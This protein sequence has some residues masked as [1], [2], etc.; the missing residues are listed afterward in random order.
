DSALDAELVEIVDT[1]LRFRHPLKRS[2]VRQAAPSAQ[3]LEMHGALDEADADPE[4]RLWHR[5]MA[6]VGCDEE[7]AAALEAHAAVA[8]RRGAVAVAGAALERAAALTPESV[9]KG[10]RL[11]RAAEVA[12]ELGQVEIVR[13]LLHQVE[14]VGIGPLEAARSA[15]LRHMITG[16]VWVQRG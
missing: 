5:A 16:D 9:R 3:R 15:W 11:V 10:E 14:A 1:E 7:L 13:P 12:Y 4:R 8:R 6:A 2:A